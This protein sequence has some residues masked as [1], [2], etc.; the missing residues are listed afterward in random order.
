MWKEPNLRTRY[1]RELW[2][3]AFC[4]PKPCGGKAFFRFWKMCPKGGPKAENPVFTLPS[5]TRKR[6]DVECPN[7]RHVV[8]RSNSNLKS[9]LDLTYCTCV[10]VE[11]PLFNQLL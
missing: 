10:R 3:T 7:L 9:Y 11:C 4:R 6:F 2:F 1:R 5:L 8:A